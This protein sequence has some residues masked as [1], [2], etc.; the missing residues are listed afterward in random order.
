MPGFTMP[1]WSLQ[2][3]DPERHRRRAQLLAEMAEAQSLRARVAQR[4]ARVDRLREIIAQRKR[5]A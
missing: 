1:S 4:R 2:R 3:L 5:I